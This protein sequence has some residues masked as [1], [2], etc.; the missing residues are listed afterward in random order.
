MQIILRARLPERPKERDEA[1]TRVKKYLRDRYTDRYNQ[2]PNAEGTPGCRICGTN[3]VGLLVPCYLL[4]SGTYVQPPSF[5]C[6]AFR[7]DPDCDVTLYSQPDGGTM[8]VV[9]VNQGDESSLI[10]HEDC[11]EL[12]INNVDMMD[13]AIE[14]IAS[15]TDDEPYNWRR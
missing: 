13:E 7:L 4:L 14:E 12:A 5:G 1:M 8:L 10:M 9:K 6:V 2:L 3:H 15:D 11:V